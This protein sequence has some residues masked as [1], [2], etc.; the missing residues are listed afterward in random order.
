MYRTLI[1]DEDTFNRKIRKERNAMVNK[2]MKEN[3]K[4]VKKAK[5][6]GINA[7]HLSKRELKKRAEQINEL[8]KAQIKES[9]KMAQL[10]KEMT[11]EEVTAFNAKIAEENS[12]Y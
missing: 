4:D 5:Q 9:N 3:R 12:K 6:Q 11:K 1:N 2:L 8:R 7:H 10:Q